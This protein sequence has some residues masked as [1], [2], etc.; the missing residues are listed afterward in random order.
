MKPCTLRTVWWMSGSGEPFRMP[1]SVILLPGGRVEEIPCASQTQSPST[2]ST[3]WKPRIVWLQR[4]ALATAQEGLS[5]LWSHNSLHFRTDTR[6]FKGIIIMSC[7]Y[8]LNKES[9]W[10]TREG[11]PSYV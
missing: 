11:F 10:K 9:L 1:V 6:T 3:Q 4:Q 2:S 8:L 5:P 7:L